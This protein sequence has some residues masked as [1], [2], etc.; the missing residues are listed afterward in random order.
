MIARTISQPSRLKAEAEQDL[1]YRTTRPGL[2]QTWERRA[3]ALWATGA[4]PHATVR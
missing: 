4:K 3:I 1:S 2:Y